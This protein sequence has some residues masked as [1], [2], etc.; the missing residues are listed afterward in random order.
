MCIMCVCQ[1]KYNNFWLIQ[2]RLYLIFFFLEISISDLPVYALN[3]LKLKIKK[4]LLCTQKVINFF[5]KYCVGE[6]VV[7]E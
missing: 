3:K 7:F 2:F 1:S 4:L 5:N 6:Y